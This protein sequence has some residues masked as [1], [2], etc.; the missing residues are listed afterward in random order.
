MNPNGPYQIRIGLSHCY[1]KLEE[2]DLAKIGFESVV[3]RVVSNL[4]RITNVWK[5]F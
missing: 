5:H 3:R 2:L 4:F 1:F